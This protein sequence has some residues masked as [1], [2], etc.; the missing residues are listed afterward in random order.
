MISEL[1]F[2]SKK[3]THRHLRGV[4]VLQGFRNHEILEEAWRTTLKEDLTG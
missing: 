2:G 4:L 3:I 1:K